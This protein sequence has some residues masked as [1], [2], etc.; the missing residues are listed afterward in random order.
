[1]STGNAERLRVEHDGLLATYN[2]DFALGYDGAGSAFLNV[3]TAVQFASDAS[4]QWIEADDEFTL[5]KT[6]IITEA[7]DELLRLTDTSATGSPFMSWYQTTTRRA[8]MQYADTGDKLKIVNEYGPVE[9]WPG[10]SGT[11]VV[12][13]TLS[14][15]GVLDLDGHIRIDRLGG[16]ADEIAM[17]FE[18]SGGDDTIFH[19]VNDGQGNYCIMV[20]VDGAAEYVATG[21]GASKILMQG[22]SA[23]GEM[24]MN[25]AAVGTAGNTV[26][27]NIGLSIDAADGK[28]RIG[29]P[30]DSTGL[31][32][33]AGFTI[34]NTSGNLY[35]Q[36]EIG[37]GIAAAVDQ[38][39]I[40]EG[41]SGEVLV[42]F[43]NTTTGAT[44][45]DGLEVGL[46]S[47]EN[48]VII[49]SETGKHIKLNA[50]GSYSL[51]IEPNQ[52][53]FGDAATS[54]TDR[55]S[56]DQDDSSFGGA[57]L[58]LAQNDTSEEYINFLT[59]AGAGAGRP[60]DNSTALGTYYARVRVAVNGSFKYLAMYNA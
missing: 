44:A 5:N 55:F 35:A 58:S 49:L 19:T 38:L 36:T 24:S 20:G 25:A 52:V 37:I 16:A 22:H 47:S 7:G 40:H 28:L 18:D 30:G 59:I 15:A 3:D 43:T 14:Q 45:S 21:D 23:T 32:G 1:M 34:A 26:S 46:D 48:A 4:L 42:R 41:S 50:T 33:G 54:G 12:R 10:A 56:I 9:F 31:D 39:Q 13:L 53:T 2:P 57:A 27:F 6:L 51:F 8:F 60:I 29:N 11:E 17:V